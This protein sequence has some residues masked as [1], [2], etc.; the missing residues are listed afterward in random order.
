MSADRYSGHTFITYRRADDIA[1]RTK[2]AT[3]QL[4]NAAKE[5]YAAIRRPLFQLHIY[6]FSRASAA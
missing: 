3:I 5:H 6:L 4:V 2:S 1:I